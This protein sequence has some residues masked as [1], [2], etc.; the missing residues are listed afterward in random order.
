MDTNIMDYSLTM[1]AD[2]LGISQK[3]QNRFDQMKVIMRLVQ[4]PSY[5]ELDIRMPIS[6]PL[7][8][9]SI[10]FDKIT[11]PSL[12]KD[13]HEVT[14]TILTQDLVYETGLTIKE[15]YSQLKYSLYERISTS[16]KYINFK[17]ISIDYLGHIDIKGRI[18]YRFNSQDSLSIVSD[19]RHDGVYIEY[20]TAHEYINPDDTKVLRFRD[21]IEVIPDNI[22]LGENAVKKVSLLSKRLD[23]EPVNNTHSQ[24]LGLFEKMIMDFKD[25]EYY[26]DCQ[27]AGKAMKKAIIEELI[28]E[29]YKEFNISREEARVVANMINEHYKI[30]TRYIKR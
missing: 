10:K 6:G 14:R 2:E 18:Q 15:F 24:T 29:Q 16:S 4:L 19:K 30:N 26:L 21:G 27:K 1:L 9:F 23:K 3:Y 17:E 8:V 25:S 5:S 11:K 28:S 7:T 13:A 20:F 12:L 22:C